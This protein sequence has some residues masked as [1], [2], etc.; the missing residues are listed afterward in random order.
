MPDQSL[1]LRLLEEALE[2]MISDNEKITARAAI[3]RMKGVLKHASDITRNAARDEI[4][5]AYKERQE[6]LRANLGAAKNRSAQDLAE[7]IEKL[8]REVEV[9]RH[10]RE[11]LIASHRAAIL[12]VGELGGAPAWLKFYEGYNAALDRLNAME[13]APVVMFPQ[14]EPT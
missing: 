10:D 2:A 1:T 12:A 5:N 9:L 11:L 8:T 6:R 13:A 14:E 4:F 3:A 7:Q